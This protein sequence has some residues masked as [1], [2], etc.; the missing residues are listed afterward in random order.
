[1]IQMQVFYSLF[2]D[3][4]DV[5][6]KLWELHLQDSRSKHIPGHHIHQMPKRVPNDQKV[7]IQEDLQEKA[8][9][10]DWLVFPTHQYRRED[11]DPINVQT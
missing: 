5:M 1:M 11:H 10:A 3:L 9:G 6:R 8:N 4:V 7:V 2:W